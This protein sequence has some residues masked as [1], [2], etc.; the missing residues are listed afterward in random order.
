MFQ[1]PISHAPLSFIHLHTYNIQHWQLCLFLVSQ[2]L[3]NSHDTRCIYWPSTTKFPAFSPTSSVPWFSSRNIAKRSKATRLWYNSVSAT[4]VTKRCNESYDTLAHHHTR[5]RRRRQ[6]QMTTQW[7]N[8][9]VKN[10]SKT[11]WE[12]ANH[13]ARRHCRRWSVVTQ[14]TGRQRQLTVFTT[15]N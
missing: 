10:V 12:L 13:P 5:M 14:Q 15:G 1:W 6:W 4:D 9:A 3:H 8:W 11:K 7:H 2:Q